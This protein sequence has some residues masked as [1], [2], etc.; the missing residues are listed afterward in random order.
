MTDK[1]NI[2]LYRTLVCIAVIEVIN[3]CLS[4]IL[5]QNTYIQYNLKETYIYIYIVLG[6]CL[7]EE[8]LLLLVI[9]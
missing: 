5:I 8:N 3:L 4:F 2:S 6:C 1:N 7:F 9:L